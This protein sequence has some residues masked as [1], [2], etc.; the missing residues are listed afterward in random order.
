MKINKLKLIVIAGTLAFIGII[1]M[2]VYLLRQAFSYEE[3]KFSQNIQVSLLEVA[4]EI[5]AYYGYQ[6]QASN[7]IEKKSADY[8]LVNLRNDFDAGVLE[9]ILTS[10]FKSKGISTNF[11]YAIY[12]C[13][14]DAM[15]YGRYVHIGKTDT[16]AINK[17]AF[18]PKASH[19]VYYFAVRFPEFNS[20]IF[21]SLK[22]WILFSVIMLIA[23]FIYLYAIYII[24]Q[25]QKFANLQRDFINNMTHE[26]KTPLASMLIAANSIL[27]SETLAADE[28]MKKYS[29]MIIDQGNKL[30]QHLEKILNIA[31]SDSQPN[32]L[33]KSLIHPGPLIRQSIESVLMKYPEAIIDF[34][35]ETTGLEILADPFHF[36]NIIYNFLDNSV[37]YCEG[38][39]RIQI[40]L[41]STT[42]AIQI[43]IS[44][45]G[46]GIP[47]KHQKQVFEKFYR[48]PGTKR[49]AVTGFGLGL[50]YV[51]QVCKLHHWKLS[52][53]SKPGNGTIIRVQINKP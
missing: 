11:E 18:F 29:Q 20:Y 24:L 45:N 33:E 39:P 9:M 16:A 50:Y 19:L 4:S 6:N 32:V 5:N 30:N 36:S 14:T 10:K 35:E 22:T 28:K 47:L 2:Q 13:E 15:M 3:K 31:R 38:Q 46:I 1:A 12:D 37:K 42:Q 17:A 41:F 44:D 52:V 34:E 7:P 48:I 49:S 53:Q 21:S 40:R 25:Q 8:Y 26:F 51:Q 27:K 43:E 23:L